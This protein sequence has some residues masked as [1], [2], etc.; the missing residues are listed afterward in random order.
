MQKTNYSILGLMSGTSL[1]GLDLA[2]VQF[3]QEDSVWRYRIQVAETISYSPDWVKELSEGINLT[4]PELA[5]LNERYTVLLA[6]LA[7]AFID[8]HQLKPDAICSHGHTIKHQPHLGYTLQIGNLPQLAALLPFPIV[9]DFRVGDVALGGQGAP[10]V[11][12][13]DELLFS[14]Y[15]FCLNLGGFANVSTN[16]Q[17]NRIAFDI[18]PV[19]T[20]LNYFAQKL[21]LEYD[22]GGAVAATG[23]V[24]EQLLADLNA[25]SFYESAHPKSLGIEFV[26]REI[27]PIL[28]AYSLAIPDVLRTFVEHISNQISLHIKRFDGRSVLIT[29]GGAYHEFLISRLRKALPDCEL[30]VPDD[31]TVAFKEAL[32]FGFLGVLRLRNEVNVLASVTGAR[33]D[34]SSGVVYNSQLL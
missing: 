4:E 33:H 16:T 25:L 17:G 22:A 7:L 3:T 20:V 28:N 15:N 10:L 14:N 5:S 1:D 30:T 34:H 2:F 26:N 32:I 11:P 12:I 9:C 31:L 23:I 8:K 24:N 29:G 6:N 18:C 21:G 19:N 27:M 13:G